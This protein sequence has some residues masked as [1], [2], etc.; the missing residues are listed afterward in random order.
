[1]GSVV[2]FQTARCQSCG[3]IL[4]FVWVN[5]QCIAYHNAPVSCPNNDTSW[6]VPI[7]QL[8][9]YVRDAVVDA[10]EGDNASF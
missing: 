5:G 9:Q 3:M 1:M 2:G 7:V 6:I 4:P 8:E 10:M